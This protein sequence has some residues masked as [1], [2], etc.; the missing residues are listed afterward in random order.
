MVATTTG[1]K[2][3]K[4]SQARLSWVTMWPLR[5]YKM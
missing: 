5:L 4:S 2:I 1:S 3:A